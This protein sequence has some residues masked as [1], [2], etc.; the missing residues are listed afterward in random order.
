LTVHIRH[1]LPHEHRIG[2]KLNFHIRE[3]G[4]EL[5]LVLLEADKTETSFY[6]RAHLL[7]EVLA[8]F[9]GLNYACPI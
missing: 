6:I 7:V 9:E 1:E 4:K 5:P 2:V 3:E 8:F